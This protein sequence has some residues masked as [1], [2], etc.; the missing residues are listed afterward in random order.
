[1]LAKLFYRFNRIN[2]SKPKTN[3]VNLAKTLVAIFILISVSLKIIPILAQSTN[4]TAEPVAEN[5]IDTSVQ[6]QLID[7]T[8]TA[9]RAGIN[10]EGWNSNQLN[11]TTINLCDALTGQC[12]TTQNIQENISQN[13]IYIPSGMLGTTNNLIAST[14]NPPASGIQYLAQVKDNI[15]G[16]PVYAQGTGFIGLEP[17]LPIWRGFR[18]VVY[19]LSTVYFIVLGIMVMFRLKINPQTILTVQSAVPQVIT[20]LLLVTFSYA[21]AGLLIDLTYLIQNLVLLLLFSVQDKGLNENLF[22]E[23]GGIR[24]SNLLKLYN[25]ET[26]SSANLIDISRMTR[27]AVPKNT[28]FLLSVVI[29]SVIGGFVGGLPTALAGAGFGALGGIIIL[30]IISLIILISMGK[31][32]FGLIKAYVNIIFKIILAP[33]EI[34]LGAIPGMKIGFSS[35][36]NNLF[37]NLLIFPICL[38]F[39]V[40]VNI[41][42]EQTSGG[43]LWAPNMINYNLSGTLINLATLPSGGLIPVAIGFTA[44]LLVSKLPELIPQVVFAIKPAS[45][46]GKNFFDTKIGQATQQAALTGG[47]FYGLNTASRTIGSIEKSS[48]LQKDLEGTEEAVDRHN[49]LQK[50]TKKAQ[51]VLHGIDDVAQISGLTKGKSLE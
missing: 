14:F 16:K 26:L 13:G 32:F 2:P 45:W 15:L 43:G 10:A 28:I 30:M 33:F 44:I 29:G 7:D 25:Y 19:L 39:L 38:L 50:W 17:L 1:M 18:N 49:K 23:T 41:I 35:W 48:E 12:P 34:G 22:R 47:I 46:A 5:E 40:L 8:H 6:D 27:L 31:F 11:T 42:I 21:I 36:A 3:L 4:P 37:A 9:L 51:T 20:T 24:W